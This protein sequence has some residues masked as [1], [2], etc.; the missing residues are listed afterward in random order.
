MSKDVVVLEDH[1]KIKESVKHVQLNNG[2]YIL[3]LVQKLS[4]LNRFAKI[5]EG[6]P[7]YKSWS[8]SYLK[9]VKGFRDRSS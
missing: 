2:H 9:S 1:P 6:G 7:Y 8:K 5:L 4:K 3:F